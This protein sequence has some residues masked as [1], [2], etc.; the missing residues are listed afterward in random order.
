MIDLSI[1]RKLTDDILHDVYEVNK[2]V[3]P[4]NQL[5]KTVM[6]PD[7]TTEPLST[8]SSSADLSI[9]VE[10]P[11]K[12][13]SR[14]SRTLTKP[15][16]VD[17]LEETPPLSNATSKNCSPMSKKVTKSQLTPSQKSPTIFKALT[18]NS[19]SIES[20][21]EIIK[22]SKND[23][24]STTKTPPDTSNATSIA[25]DLTPEKE[26]I[27]EPEF[28]S[29]I[30]GRRRIC[31][32]DFYKVVYP[33]P[34]RRRSADSPR[35]QVKPKSNK[36]INNSNQQKGWRGK[37]NLLSSVIDSTTPS[38]LKSTS[39]S[40]LKSTSASPLKST[41][42]SSPTPVTTT[43]AKVQTPEKSEDAD[44]QTVTPIA[45]E[46]KVNITYIWSSLVI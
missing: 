31:Q 9:L 30:T 35:P 10:P 26:K 16:F 20:D 32:T 38:P 1:A 8:S 12:P 6:V 36:E 39:A 21:V 2:A 41:S 7:S 34:K 37:S 13:I 29:M 22:Q 4:D 46:E 15:Y 24:I 14:P 5:N 23:K 27:N 25:K 45:E 33:Q 42:T 19:P 17:P 43:S 18:T 40:P 44:G 28:T 11:N 3:K